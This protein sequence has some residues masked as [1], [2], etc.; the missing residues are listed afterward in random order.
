MGEG[1]CLIMWE[2]MTSYSYKTTYMRIINE[3]GES[4]GDDTE[5]PDIRLN[6][7][8]VLRYNQ[9]TGNVHWAVNNGS[10]EII[11]Y[12]LNP[13]DLFNSNIDIPKIEYTSLKGEL[14]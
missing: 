10:R 11:V 6:L 4:S 8:D 5:L 9:I 12:S 1:R 14:R 3:K 2:C 7:N 13:D